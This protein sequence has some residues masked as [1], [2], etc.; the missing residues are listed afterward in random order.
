MKEDY[1]LAEYNSIVSEAEELYSQ[2]NG[3]CEGDYAE[4]WEQAERNFHECKSSISPTE[5]DL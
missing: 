2:Q 5:Q 4:A 1:T 3:S